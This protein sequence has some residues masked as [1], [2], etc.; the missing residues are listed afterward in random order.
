M[1][2]KVSNDVELQFKDG[3]P[4]ARV[5]AGSATCSVAKTDTAEPLLVQLAFPPT[6]THIFQS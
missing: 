3:V 2:L 4:A 6:L 5:A 1:H